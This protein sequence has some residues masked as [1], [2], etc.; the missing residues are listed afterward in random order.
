MQLSIVATLYRS[1]PFLREFHER[2][3]RQAAQ[4]TDD[5]EIVLVND[6]CPEGSL[7]LALALRREDPRIKVIDLSRNFGHHK[8]MMTGLAHARGRRVF[9]IDCDLEEPPELL[10]DFQRE[11]ERSGSDVVYGVQKQRRGGVFE[12]VSGALFFR[13]FNLLSKHRLPPNLCTV[14]LMS[15]RYVRQLVAHRERET[16]ISGLWMLTGFEQRALSVEKAWRRQSNYSLAS[17][18]VLLVD[19]ITSFSDRPL[20]LVFYLGLTIAILASMAALYLIVR[21]VFF[22]VFLA[23]WPS[24]IVS[25][26]LLGGLTIFCVG[27]VGMYVSRVFIETKKRPYTVVR[28]IHGHPRRTRAASTL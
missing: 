28:K 23:G 22:G 25:I 14:R 6:G 10:G 18:V 13:V 9:L 8:A 19:S 16:V 24:V 4:L 26:W 21:R 2:I 27:L 11:M 20:V 3:V 7:D 17:R 1:A 12:R 15:R 5:F